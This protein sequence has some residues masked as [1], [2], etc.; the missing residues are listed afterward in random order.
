MW[1]VL[2]NNKENIGG[3]YMIVIVIVSL[4]MVLLGAFTLMYQMFHIVVLDAESRGLKH[5]KFWGIFSLGGNN[6]SSGLILYLIGRNR[7][8]S[9]MS[10]AAK[11]IFNSCKKKTALSLCFIASGS[12]GLI[13]MALFG[14]L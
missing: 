4:F 6:G 3:N 10:D 13:F 12:I 8:P 5:P 14:N 11:E 9:N 2:S 1:I 7:Y